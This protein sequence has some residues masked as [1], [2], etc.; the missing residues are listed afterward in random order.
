MP[1]QKLSKRNIDFDVTSRKSQ[2]LWGRELAPAVNSEIPKIKKK[3][4]LEK[5]TD[6]YE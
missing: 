4:R 2:N 3:G 6:C 5:A 1:P